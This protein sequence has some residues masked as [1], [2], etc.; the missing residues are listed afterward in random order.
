M[1]DMKGLFITVFSLFIALGGVAQNRLSSIQDSMSIYQ[2]MY[3]RTITSSSSKCI[4]TYKNTLSVKGLEF[5]YYFFE[6]GNSEK[7]RNLMFFIPT[8]RTD[9]F[10]NYSFK[11]LMLRS[12]VSIIPYTSFGS[13]VYSDCGVSDSFYYF[14]NHYDYLN[15]C[16]SKMP[17]NG[18]FYSVSSKEFYTINSVNVVVDK[19]EL[20]TVFSKKI[21]PFLDFP[22]TSSI[23]HYRY[24]INREYV[25]KRILKDKRYKKILINREC[26]YSYH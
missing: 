5:H 6:D 12:V 17:T 13:I 22:N 26:S 1:M 21:F 23:Y 4:A 8:N 14:N 24:V 3:N 18:L 19:F 15:N 25:S 16:F 11:E 9:T 20:D 2:E 10:K 7:C